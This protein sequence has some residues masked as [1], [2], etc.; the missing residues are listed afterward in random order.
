[1][2]TEI[3]GDIY[4]YVYIQ[5]SY[6]F[7]YNGIYAMV[8]S[9]HMGFVDS[10]IVFSMIDHS[11]S[12]RVRDLLRFKRDRTNYGLLVQFAAFQV[13]LRL[14]MSKRLR[15]IAYVVVK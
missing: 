2:E 10:A 13:T 12:F 9:R 4:L 7:P 3:L 14:V 8:Y 6:F 15:L 11:R 5:S 1:M